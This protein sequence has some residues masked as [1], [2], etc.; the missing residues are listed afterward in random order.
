MHG[1]RAKKS[2]KS[3][4]NK[5][6]EKLKR[7]AQ[8][9]PGALDPNFYIKALSKDNE[10]L[11]AKIIECRVDHQ[12]EKDYETTLDSVRKSIKKQ[13]TLASTDYQYYIHYHHMNRRLDEW[14]TADRVQT[15]TEFID[16]DWE[17]KRDKE[18]GIV[19]SSDEEHEGFDDKQLRDHIEKTKIKTINK[20]RFGE[21][22]T[23]TWYY[24]PFPDGYHDIDCLY[25]CEYCLS[26][27][28]S[29][30]ALNRHMQ[31]CTLLHPPGNE[32]YRDPERNL[33][34]FEVDGFRNP[35]YCENL[36]YLAKLFLDH[37][38]LLHTLDWFLFF[39]LTVKDDYGYHVV[40]YFSKPKDFTLKTN[41]S[42]ILTLPFHQRKGYGKLL[43]NMSYE[44]SKLEKRVGSPERPLSDLGR[45]TYLG[46]WTQKIIEYILKMDGRPFSLDD[47]VT[48]TSITYMD[49]TV[50]L[51][52][53][54][55]IKKVDNEVIICTNKQILEAIYRKMG[56]PAIEV[57]VENIHWEP[58][59]FDYF[60][61]DMNK[62]KKKKKR[63]LRDRLRG[64]RI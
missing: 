8:D 28:V 42:C 41:L 39:V 18:L 63:E 49:V 51:E 15:T 38:E 4:K 35:A 1:K 26:F 7:Y 11:K 17:K 30:D 33:A 19:H 36:G 22:I 13:R 21:H 32:M 31:K 52:R 20:I 24:S 45:I 55:L 53:V 61:E 58:F 27:F 23:D 60:E 56:R 5:K 37:K 2:V 29:E 40:G 47:I 12:K 43:I 57:K 14:V 62:R 16:E 6:N 9:S 59:S 44:L 64:D 34:M 25:F 50:S 46:F 10:W 48:A 54:N 3:K